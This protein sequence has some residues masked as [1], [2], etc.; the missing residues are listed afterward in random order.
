MV[1]KLKGNDADELFKAILQLKTVDECYALFEDLCTIKELQSM[2]QRF[3]VAKMLR[4]KRVYSDIVEQT[5]AS[6][7]T[8]RRVNRS[9]LYGKD[10][11]ELVLE[12]LKEAE[13]KA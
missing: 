5:G 3:V 9:L 11:Y 6:T 7:A 10:G 2:T 1:D 8:I 4:E 13:D 12:R